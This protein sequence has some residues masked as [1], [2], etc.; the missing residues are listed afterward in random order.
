VGDP[1]Q[2]LPSRGDRLRRRGA[3]L[4]QLQQLV[5]YVW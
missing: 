5:L 1:A 4:L 2:R 3:V